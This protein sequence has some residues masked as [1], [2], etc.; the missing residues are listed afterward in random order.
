MDINQIRAFIAAADFQSFTLAADYLYITQS[1]ISKRIAT[2]EIEIK[3]RLFIREHNRL[4]L[5]EAG[6]IFLPYAIETLQT[7][8][9]GISSVNLFLE[10][11]KKTLK[12]GVDFLIGS[13]MLPDLLAAFH[14]EEPNLD[15]SVSYLSPLMSFRALRNREIEICLNCINKKI[16]RE[17]EL[18]PLFTLPYVIKVSRSHPLFNQKNLSL[19]K[20]MSYPGI[21]MPKY[22]PPRQA[23]EEYLFR[24]NLV[25]SAQ[26]EA[27][28]IFALLK[29][30]KLGLGWCFIPKNII[31]KDLVTIYEHEALQM[32]YFIIYR[33]AHKLSPDAQKFI[34]TLRETH[35]FNN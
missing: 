25:L 33:K 2:L 3:T 28:P 19:Q 26:H 11:Q 18:I 24:K 8:Q 22:A 13:F 21:V 12:V 14:H 27:E 10:K 29:L 23:L 35:F 31:D 4:T 7:I 15:F 30:A 1:A 9:S 34:A 16:A 6:K 5:T 20:I 32:S 17:F